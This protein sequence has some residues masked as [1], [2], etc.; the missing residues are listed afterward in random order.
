MQQ[1]EMHFNDFTLGT[2]FLSATDQELVGCYVDL[3][4]LNLKKRKKIC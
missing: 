3:K 4:T 2:V 1:V